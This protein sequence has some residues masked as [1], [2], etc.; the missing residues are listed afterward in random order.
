MYFSA[1]TTYN[2]S[3]IIKRSGIFPLTLRTLGGVIMNFSKFFLTAFI[4]IYS[5]SAFSLDV[6]DCAVGLRK[7]L[8]F[9]VPRFDIGSS[10][11]SATFQIFEDSS[12][13]LMARLLDFDEPSRDNCVE[14]NIGIVVIDDNNNYLLH[15]P[16][17]IVGTERY[18]ANL[19]Y[20]PAS[21]KEYEFEIKKYAEEIKGFN[22]SGSAFLTEAETT[23][24][25]STDTKLHL[26]SRLPGG[27]TANIV[28]YLI[29]NQ[30]YTPTDEEI[31]RANSRGIKVFTKKITHSDSSEGVAKYTLEFFVPSEDLPFSKRIHEIVPL[32]K[33]ASEPMKGSNVYLETTIDGIKADTY[34]LLG[35][36]FGKGMGTVTSVGLD[37]KDLFF[38]WSLKEENMNMQKRLDAA[39]RCVNKSTFFGSKS[40]ALS[41]IKGTRDEVRHN[42]VLPVI[43][44][45]VEVGAGYVPASRI[46]SF[47]LSR[48]S[49]L[50][51]TYT[52]E[53]TY[54][55]NDLKV[56]IIERNFGKCPINFAVGFEGY[57]E[58]YYDDFPEGGLDF[59]SRYT[60]KKIQV[61][62]HI[63][64]DQVDF[65]DN[66][67]GRK[68]SP[69][70][71]M[72]HTKNVGST[73]T[74]ASGY[75]E[76]LTV[77]KG[78]AK[79]C[80][81]VIYDVV[82]IDDPLLAVQLDDV[83]VSSDAAYPPSPEFI[84]RVL[85]FSDVLWNGTCESTSG[86]LESVNNR[87]LG[88]GSFSPTARFN[89]PKYF[90]SGFEVEVTDRSWPGVTW[91]GVVTFAPYIAE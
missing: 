22:A 26:E 7:D 13:K 65:I 50:L 23:I 91:E 80:T 85:G 90:R 10:S 8:S 4:S 66:T 49:S 5:L 12:G 74:E 75:Y 62:W 69:N 2:E 77:Y 6:D 58:H 44:K 43:M 59:S 87:K 60:Q 72:N 57:L 67:A 40:D 27:L 35:E 28:A 89:T 24:I 86:G 46:L 36:Q 3:T 15:L 73:Y 78:I 56:S 20:N 18:W 48:S 39:E 32:A 25:E 83:Y 33:E 41:K 64:R 30:T 14:R 52:E 19:V 16:S 61:R 38:D 68:F 47:L 63:Y 11:H 37:I 53:A 71:G 21:H 55:H 42:S 45:I 34:E 54:E 51:N 9:H 84:G 79:L 82:P 88:M 17:V 81:G 1:P 76:S 70:Y 31:I 29:E